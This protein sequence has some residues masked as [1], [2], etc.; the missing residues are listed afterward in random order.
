M[1]SEEREA[2]WHPAVI[3]AVLPLLIRWHFSILKDSANISGNK[4]AGLLYFVYGTESISLFAVC[5]E[6][7]WHSTRSTQNPSVKAGE[8][9]VPLVLMLSKYSFIKGFHPDSLNSLS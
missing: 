3:F 8:K 7:S 6:R 4:E 5:Q 9:I 1:F 2:S